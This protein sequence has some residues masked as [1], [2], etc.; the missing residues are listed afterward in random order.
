MLDTELT[1][2]HMLILWVDMRVLDFNGL[3]RSTSE[4]LAQTG[5]ELRGKACRAV[6]LGNVNWEISV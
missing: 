2:S 4:A 1:V 5:G 6:E 3:L